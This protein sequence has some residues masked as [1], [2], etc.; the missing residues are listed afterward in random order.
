MIRAS[1]ACT[2]AFGLHAVVF[3]SGDRALRHNSGTSALA[4]SIT[5]L[6]AGSERDLSTIVMCDIGFRIE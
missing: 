3:M 5:F 4:Y 6:D 2:T 1:P